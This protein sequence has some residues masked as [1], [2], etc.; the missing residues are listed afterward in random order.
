MITF[1]LYPSPPTPLPAGE[2]SQS[3]FSQREKGLGDEGVTLGT[4]QKILEVIKFT[5]LRR[6]QA[7]QMTVPFL[8]VLA[9]FFNEG[10]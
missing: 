8:L 1:T 5:I 6:S 2:E 4:F 3:P 9:I 7:S 10:I